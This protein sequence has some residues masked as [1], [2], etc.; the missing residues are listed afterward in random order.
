[1]FKVNPYKKIKVLQNNGFIGF[2][3]TCFKYRSWGWDLLTL[4]KQKCANC[5]KITFFLKVQP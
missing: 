5:I 3:K 4:G 1:M 2:D